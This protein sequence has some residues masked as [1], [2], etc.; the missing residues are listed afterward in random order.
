MKDPEM[1]HTSG[2]VEISMKAIFRGTKDQD[3]VFNIMQMEKNML[4]IG[5]MTIEMDLEHLT[6]QME[7]SP[8]MECGL[9]MSSNCNN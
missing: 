8:L 2:R 4:A 5:Q 6:Q 1:E 3:M 9:I 7:L